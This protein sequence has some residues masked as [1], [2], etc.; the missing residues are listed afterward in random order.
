MFAIVYKTA[1]MEH[2]SKL[3]LI[4][5]G[6]FLSEKY[7]G[8]KFSPFFVSMLEK[9]LHV[10]A[11]NKIITQIGPGKQGEEFCSAA[12]K[13]FGYNVE[14]EGLE[15]VPD[16]GTLYTFASNHPLGGGDGIILCSLVGEKFGKLKFPINDFLMAIK[17]L[18]ALSVPINKLG[19]QARNLPL[20]IKEAYQS[21]RHVVIFPAGICSRKIDGKVTDL[22]WNKSFIKLSREN[23]RKIVPVHFEGFNSDRF[24]SVA[25][26][27]KKLGIKFNIAMTMLPGEL[28]RSK[29]KRFKVTFGKPINP[30]FFDKS[31][32]DL[33]WAAF[34][35]EQ[36]LSL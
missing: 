21:D 23:G 11:L 18:R 5:L 8:K 35:R 31:K 24:Y 10:K 28:L 29:G 15:N 3:E 20:L 6:E 19:A 12:V 30:E 34:V 9:L 33:E 27:S 4:D 32:N 16:D 22:K 17:P 36:A 1:L 2:T 26:L 7:N 14:V 13:E 25:N